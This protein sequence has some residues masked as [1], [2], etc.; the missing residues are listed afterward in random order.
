MRTPH[1]GYQAEA[2]REFGPVEEVGLGAEDEPVEDACSVQ[3]DCPGAASAREANKAKNETSARCMGSNVVEG[4][5]YSEALCSSI[6]YL[7]SARPCHEVVVRLEERTRS[8]CRIVRP[9]R[10]TKESGRPRESWIA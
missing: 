5:R 9:K 4:V 1:S 3:K 8:S 7:Y 2:M 10:G 6:R